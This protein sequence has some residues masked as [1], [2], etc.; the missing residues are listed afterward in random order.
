MCNEVKKFS[1]EAA[2]LLNG[3]WLYSSQV[4]NAKGLAETVTRAALE[5]YAN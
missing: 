2:L 5:I 4:G 1:N 3:Y